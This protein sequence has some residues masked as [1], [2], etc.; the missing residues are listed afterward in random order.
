MA[1]TKGNTC[2]GM[3]PPVF[4][5]TNRLQFGYI[6]AMNGKRNLQ[7]ALFLVGAVGA[8]VALHRIELPVNT[9][10]WQAMNSRLIHISGR[11]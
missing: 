4:M 6:G 8:M 2:D 11:R 5:L 3:M 10:L 9:Y 1:T 7:A